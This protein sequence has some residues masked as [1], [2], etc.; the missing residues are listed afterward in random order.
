MSTS[1]QNYR[2]LSRGTVIAAR[3]EVEKYLGESLLGPTYVV[4]NLDED[5]LL[6]LKFIRT[7]YH[8]LEEADRL[9]NLMQ[10][11]RKIQHPNVVRYG[12]VGEYRDMLFFTQEDFPSINLRQLLLE[13]QA[14]NKD[15]SAAES[16]QVISKA[17]DALSA[18]HEQG[19]IHTN[20]KPENIL[21]RQRTNDDGQTIREVKITDLMAASILGDEMIDESPYRSPECRPEFAMFSKGPESDVFSIGNIL[22]ELLV[23]RPAQGTYVS[24]SQFRNE[25][26]SSVDNVIDVAL[27][28]DPSRRYSSANDMKT[29]IELIL[30]DVS[31]KP[32]VSIDHKNLIIAVSI[33]I[34]ALAIIGFVF[35]LQGT[36]EQNR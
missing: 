7:E 15:F 8:P 9:K 22:Y 32:K 13:H 19:L 26:D 3:Y 36:Q 34:A 1:N 12:N 31:N 30:D 28:T 10:A 4:K 11:A 35:L 24:P 6:A 2:P 23:G 33:G 16:F 14:E 25:I 17:L 27:S 5:K 29:N 20:I 18:I 21:V